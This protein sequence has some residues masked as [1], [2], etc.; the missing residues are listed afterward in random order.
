[1]SLD[2]TGLTIK[3]FTQI[4]EELNA[5]VKFKLGSSVDTSEN[6]LLGHLHSNFALRLA[7]L[8][9]LSQDIYDAGRLYDAEG[10]QLDNLVLHVGVNR[11]SATQA[12]G[13]VRFTG[14]N[15]V[16]IPAGTRLGSAKGDEFITKEAF[17]INSQRC[18]QT[19]IYVGTVVDDTDYTLTMDGAGYS[20]DSGTSATEESILTLIG[21][22]LDAGGITTNTVVVDALV[23]ANTYLLVDKDDK[24]DE[25]AISGISYLK[26]DHVV[27][28]QTVYS[29]EYGAISGDADAITIILSSVTNWYSAVNPVNLTSGSEIETDN[30]LRL[31]AIG[32]YDAAGSGT[33][34]AITTS[35]LRL[36]GVKDCIVK[37]NATSVT[38]DSVPPKSYEVV[39]NGGI[40]SEIAQ[41][42][43]DTKPAGIYTYGSNSETVVDF[44]GYTQTVNFSPATPIYVTVRV[45]YAT[46]A[47]E[48][49]PI[50]AIDAAK[51]AILQF[52]NDTL[53][54]DD[55][56]I[57]KRFL[58]VIY[59]A[60][61]GFGD[62]VIEVATK[63][64]PNDTVA[65][66][67]Y[68]QHE[69]ISDREVGSFSSVRL[70]FQTM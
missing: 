16:V 23:P 45:T 48:D 17:S 70:I 36:D 46:Y 8:W 21:T 57:A 30:E 54:M 2:T 69:A 11:K 19:R 68:S 34:D 20:V 35:V 13:Y 26:F 24:T 56:I 47:E 53:T 1:M 5:G 62:I 60:T 14:L 10:T 38:V 43:W 50:G 3:R 49:L 40:D 51:D 39:V 44:N 61:T 31:R 33:L 4:H 15:G 59:G 66:E 7:E 67:D 12:Q 22:A 52:A 28:Q 25:L 9:E 41:V 42:V 29:K 65:N 37:E 58:G 32:E 55:D 6:S 63:P 27:T 64:A 18:L